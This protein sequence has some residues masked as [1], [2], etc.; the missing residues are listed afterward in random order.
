MN[1][2]LICTEDS[3]LARQLIAI[4]KSAGL[5]VHTAA[6]A[7]LAFKLMTEHQPQLVLLDQHF[8]EKTALDVATN[9]LSLESHARIVLLVREESFAVSRAALRAGIAELVVVPGETEKLGPLLAGLNKSVETQTSHTYGP[10]AGFFS[11]KGGTGCSL[12]AINTAVACASQVPNGV[13]LVDA[14]LQTGDVSGML[15]IKA[16]RNMAHLLPVIDELTP[17][18]IRDVCAV[19]QSG[20]SVLLAPTDPALSHALQP[21]HLARIVRVARTFFGAVIVDCPPATDPVCGAVLEEASHP[22]LVC[23]PD[24]PNVF[25]WRRL[26]R[27]VGSVLQRTKFVLNQIS[28]KSELNKADFASLL[29]LENLGEIRLDSATITPLVNTGKTLFD[30]TDMI[31]K[32]RRTPLAQD[33][34]RLARRL[35]A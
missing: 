24:V 4:A 18:H 25:A 26:K 15:E 30:E 32:P 8:E 28:P 17:G 10:V 3:L 13:L 1:N 19:H 14:N 9:L 22:I 16:E 11:V 21:E 34:M 31:K 12:L 5:G 29:E 20:I 6:H 2:V 33:V 27:H 35:L 23:A 7:S